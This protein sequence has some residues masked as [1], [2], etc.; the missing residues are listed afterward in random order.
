MYAAR[1]MWEIFVYFID[2]KNGK[3]DIKGKVLNI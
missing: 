3:Q 1:I 2:L